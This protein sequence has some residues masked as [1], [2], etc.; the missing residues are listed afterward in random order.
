MRQAELHQDFQEE[1]L[2]E[3]R[4][5]ARHAFSSGLKVPGELTAN[6]ERLS[7]LVREFHRN[8]PT[9]HEP[10][11]GTEAF[12]GDLAGVHARLAEIV[13]PAKPGSLLFLARDA[14]RTSNWL[15]FVGP[16]PLVRR[17]MAVAVCSLVLLI[18]VSVS[19]HVNGDPDR[20]SLFENDGVSLL[21]NFMFLLASSSLGACFSALFM[22]NR[23]IQRGTFHPIYESSYWVRY[24]LGLL[25]GTMIAVLIPIE[26]IATS[27]GGRTTAVTLEGLGQ[28]LLA[29]LGGFSSSVVHR[30]LKRLVAA[31]ETIVRG[32]QQ[33][34]EDAREEEGRARLLEKDVNNRLALLGRLRGLQ[35][36][37][38]ARA[39]ADR[40][41]QELER[42]Q[43]DLIVPGS[44]ASEQAGAG[45]R[46]AAGKTRASKKK[47]SS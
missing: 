11:Q 20:F 16:V 43:S 12:A 34:L 17:M 31:V 7:A 36:L 5:M 33:S 27:E 44:Y 32:D 39:G 3:C 30:I 40:L 4:A 1:L 15:R 21:L 8:A 19:P 46:S 47:A 25:A 14:A 26:W 10:F 45:G 42:I 18:A 24:V 23:Y 29:L 41:R 35:D 37:M 28:P 22:A 6:L 13:A 2:A 9:P 38:D